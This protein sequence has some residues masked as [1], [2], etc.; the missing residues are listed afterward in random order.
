MPKGGCSSCAI[1]FE[2]AQGGSC[3]VG[4]STGASPWTRRYSESCAKKSG[5][6]STCAARCMPM[7]SVPS[8]STSVSWHPCEEA[9]WRWTPKSF[10]KRASL[11]RPSWNASCGPGRERVSTSPSRTRHTCERSSDGSRNRLLHHDIQSRRIEAVEDVVVLGEGHDDQ[12]VAAAANLGL[13]ERDREVRANGS[14]QKRVPHDLSG[15]G[16]GGDAIHVD[17]Q[18]ALARRRSL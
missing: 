12:V 2:R 4:L 5:S 6:T 16:G 8:T 13:A 9:S 15:V 14:R 1:G 10:S 18:M 3:R 11:R 17:L 7:W